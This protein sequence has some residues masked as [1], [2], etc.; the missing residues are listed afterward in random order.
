MSIF[1]SILKA[2]EGLEDKNPDGYHYDEL[3]SLGYETENILEACS[4]FSETQQYI[5]FANEGDISCT[6]E[7]LGLDEFGQ[8]DD[9]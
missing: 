1:D 3:Q 7:E 9:D 6:N 2:F 4:I 8:R 5:S